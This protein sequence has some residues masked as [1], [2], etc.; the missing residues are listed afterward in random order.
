MLS[1][2]L[3][4]IEGKIKQ[5]IEKLAKSQEE[6]DALKKENK[7]IRTELKNKVDKIG[8]LEYKVSKTA[9]ALEKKRDEDP[10]SSKDLRKEIDSY[11]SEI[12]K[13]IEWL[14]NH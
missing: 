2:Q 9:Q 7:Y 8:S 13:C 10:K 6:V 12:D 1:E 3:N 4:T 11:I 5:L 14:Q